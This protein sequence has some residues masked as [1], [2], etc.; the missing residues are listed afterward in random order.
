M[1]PQ[2]LV[3]SHLLLFLYT[4]DCISGDPSSK[5]LN[6]MDDTTLIGFIS[7]SEVEL[8]VS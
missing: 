3:L 5:L 8:Q 1:P 6:F 7:E 4:N 2:G